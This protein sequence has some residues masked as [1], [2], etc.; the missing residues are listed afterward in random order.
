M[1]KTRHPM[2]AQEK[3][4]TPQEEKEIFAQI[5]KELAILQVAYPSQVRNFSPEETS[6]AC[7]LWYEIFKGVH[8]K[9]LHQA[10]TRFIVTDKKAFFPTPGLIVA[11]VEEI[12]AELEAKKQIAEDS[13]Y[14]EFALKEYKALEIAEKR[15]DTSCTITSQSKAD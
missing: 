11:Q 3:A 15:E 8:P 12:L 9:L 13:K 6:V 2:L 5:T 4:L 1:T 10:V 14:L 7:A